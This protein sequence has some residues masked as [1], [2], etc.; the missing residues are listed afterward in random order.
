[1]KT[2]TAA[3]A[4]RFYPRNKFDLADMIKDIQ[5]SE[6]VNIDYTLAE[7]RIIGGI[8]PH[9]G[10][11]YSG[12]EAVHFFDI[13]KKS[14]QKFD[15]VVVVSPNHTG[16][17]AAISLDSVPFWETPLGKV[18][19]DLEFQ[20]ELPFDYATE[21]HKYE[22]S[23]EVVVPFLQQML[24]YPFQLVP[25]TI[26]EQ[27][28]TNARK[29]A[30]LVYEAATRLE[31]KVLLIASSD[32]SHFVAPDEGIQQDDL[33]IEQILAF[34]SENLEQVVKRKRI[35]MCGCAPIMTLLEY[36]QIVSGN[37]RIKLLA[38]GNS[39]R[40]YPSVEVVDYVSF[41]VYE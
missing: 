29:I 3:V 25:I 28:L 6:K 22:H 18:A 11:K 9:A 35:S 26:L 1:M 23:I 27:N 7:N 5:K 15:T 17:G 31:R 16:Y 4:G 36:A 2:R 20:A 12:H 34:D 21:A 30:A 41:L 40:S 32:F 13:L 10:Y 33:A 38:R 14:T 24:P 19:L 8:V 37:P 39:A